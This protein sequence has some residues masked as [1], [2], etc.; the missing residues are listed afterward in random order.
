MDYLLRRFNRDDVTTFRAAADYWAG[1]IGRRQSKVF[2]VGA[3]QVKVTAENHE[4]IELVV[5]YGE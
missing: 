5:G 4:V 2:T 1:T 3:Y